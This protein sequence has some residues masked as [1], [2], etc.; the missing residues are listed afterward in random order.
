MPNYIYTILM[1]LV[2]RCCVFVT[3]KPSQHMIT[4]MIDDEHANEKL[5][6]PFPTIVKSLGIYL[7]EVW[8]YVRFIFCLSFTC[9]VILQ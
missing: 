2:K 5:N 7:I 6:N 3:Q 4:S 1:W 9:C 8:L